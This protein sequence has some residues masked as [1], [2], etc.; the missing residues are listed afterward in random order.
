MKKIIKFIIGEFS[1]LCRVTVKTLRHYEEIGLLIPK[2][3]D[4]WTRYRFY[5]LSQL[6]R[7]SR[8]IY[9]KDLGFSL[10]EIKNLF[11]EGGQMPSME[12]IQ[13]KS[14]QCREEVNKWMK[15]QSELFKLEAIFY[16]QE[17]I[18]EKVF[19]KTLPARIFA[20]HRRKIDSYDEW[21]TEIQLPVKK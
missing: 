2:E 5:D 15:R 16:K 20:T 17:N 9:L 7:M 21:L 12:M 1:K 3:V 11:E 10:E 19:E 13:A 18:M 6:R 14:K 8:I 4:E